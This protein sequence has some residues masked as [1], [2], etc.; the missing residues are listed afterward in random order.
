MT[1]LLYTPCKLR[2]EYKN[3]RFC[4]INTIFNF[5]RCITVVKRNSKCTRLKNTKIYRQPL[6][7]VHKKNCNLISFFYTTAKQ[8]ICKSVCFFIKFIPCNFCTK[9]IFRSA[10]YKRILSPCKSFAF[11][12]RWIYFNK[13]NIIFV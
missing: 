11:F 3:I 10:F 5:I 6:K 7:T 8:Q 2:T 12:K 1:N 9:S 4:E 13:T